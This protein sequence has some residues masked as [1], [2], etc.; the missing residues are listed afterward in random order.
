M[1]KP[2]PIFFICDICYNKIITYNIIIYMK[3][4]KSIYKIIIIFLLFFSFASFV[5]AETLGN[6]NTDSITSS[7]CNPSKETCL[8]NP[9]GSIDTPQAFIKKV[10]DG[11]LGV[12]G[13]L[14]LIMFVYGG[15]TWMMASGNQ[16]AIKKGK[17]ILIWA[18]IGLVVIFSAYAITNFIFK[19]IGA[20]GP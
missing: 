18:A 10:I 8:S 11:V 2:M 13:S 15:F 5:S 14:A 12:V 6:P 17:D 4:F 7:P 3:I 16:E 20:Y 1:G 9:L 19:G